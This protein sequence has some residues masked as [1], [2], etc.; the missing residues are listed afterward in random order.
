[1][2]RITDRHDMTSAVYD[3]RPFFMCANSQDTAKIGQVCRPGP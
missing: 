2:V 3:G 1:M